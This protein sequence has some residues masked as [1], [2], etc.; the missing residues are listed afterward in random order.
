MW[1]VQISEATVWKTAEADDNI[2]L[3]LNEKLGQFNEI[4]EYVWGESYRWGD[5]TFK[6]RESIVEI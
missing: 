3:K 5:I 2:E 4:I 6:R 1:V